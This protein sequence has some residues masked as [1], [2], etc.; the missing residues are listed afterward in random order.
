MWIKRE[1]SLY[2]F[3]LTGNNNLRIIKRKELSFG[4]CKYQ[5]VIRSQSNTFLL[6]SSGRKDHRNDCLVLLASGY[7]RHLN[8]LT[9]ISQNTHKK[10]V[11]IKKRKNIEQARIFM[12]FKQDSTWNFY[13]ALFLQSSQFKHRW[14]HSPTCD[15]ISSEFLCFSFQF[16]CQSIILFLIN[17]ILS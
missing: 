4:T 16:P 17:F 11:Y 13:W 7:S 5:E 15:V 14:N 12:N 10:K 2:A 1:F 6:Y 3:G 9:F 8:Q